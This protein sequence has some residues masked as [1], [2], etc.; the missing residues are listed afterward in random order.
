MQRRPET[1]GAWHLH[2][3]AE[4]RLLTYSG[5][6]LLVSKDRA[7]FN[8]VVTSTI[9]F[10]GDAS[11]QPAKPY[12]EHG[13]FSVRSSAPSSVRQKRSVSQR[14]SGDTCASAQG[15]AAPNGA[16]APA[17]APSATT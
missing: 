1:S 9:V 6:I 15:A 16:A 11:L 8:N 2:Q 12:T 7:F 3:L 14:V 10:E 17:A 4:E 5:T 13:A